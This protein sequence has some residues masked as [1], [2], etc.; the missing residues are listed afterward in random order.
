MGRKTRTGISQE[1]ILEFCHE[2]SKENGTGIYLGSAEDLLIEAQP[3]WEHLSEESQAKLN[4]TLYD[5]VEHIVI[6]D[7]TNGPFLDLFLGRLEDMT[8]AW[9]LYVGEEVDARK[10]PSR[11]W[12][13]CLREI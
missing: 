3:D 1:R 5:Q 7:P 8:V 6:N 2:R 10:Q 12:L 4:K 9:L 13:P 11:L